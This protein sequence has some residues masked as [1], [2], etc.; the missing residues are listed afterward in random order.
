MSSGVIDN[1]IKGNCVVIS[2][3]YSTVA[4]TTSLD[5]GI[6]KACFYETA[7]ACKPEMQA[8]TI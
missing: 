2:L 8:G 7:V 6:L 1:G 4:G 3:M 5:Y